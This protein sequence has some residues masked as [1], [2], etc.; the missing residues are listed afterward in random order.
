MVVESQL[1][2]PPLASSATIRNEILNVF[3]M[4]LH[5]ALLIDSGT[6]R[7]HPCRSLVAINIKSIDLY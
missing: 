7:Q 6:Q 3:E 4:I 2:K 1:G 5:S